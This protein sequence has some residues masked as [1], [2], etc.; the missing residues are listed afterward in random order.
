M[1]RPRSSDRSPYLVTT[2]WRLAALAIL[3]P[4][5]AAACS[6]GPG[7]DDGPV[8]RATHYGPSPA[9]E[10]P[11]GDSPFVQTTAPPVDPPAAEFVIQTDDRAELVLRGRL[12][13][14]DWITWQGENKQQPA[15]PV[16]W[17]TP[18][19]VSTPQSLALLLHAAS[20]PDRVVVHAFTDVDVGTGEPTSGPT[21]TFQCSRF[22]PPTCVYTDTDSGIRVE[23]LNE[24]V[25]DL[26]YVTVFCSWYVPRAFRAD[27]PDSPSQ[28]SASW[29]F[30]IDRSA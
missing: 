17:P 3:G 20:P 8:A 2:G 27:G 19:S 13:T 15:L 22:Q 6:G 16:P 23:A 28:A 11:T 21:V 14:S 24:R 26:G 4:M 5:L 7:P 10:R 1:I 29:L 30:R 9:G 12:Y 18:S 25:V